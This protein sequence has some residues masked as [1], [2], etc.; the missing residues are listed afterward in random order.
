MISSVTTT[1][2]ATVG[3][4]SPLFG[5]ITVVLLLALLAQKELASAHPSGWVQ[6]VG[7]IL[8]IAIIPLLIAFGFTVTVRVI[9]V[10]TRNGS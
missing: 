2:I 1:T 7:R 10:L 3:A 9:E 4:M 6:V 5:A 8:N